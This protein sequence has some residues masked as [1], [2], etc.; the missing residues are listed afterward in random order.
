M[1]MA[2]VEN[3]ALSDAYCHQKGIFPAREAVVMQQQDRGIEGVHA[4]NVFVGNGVSE[5]IMQCMRALLDPGDGLGPS[6]DYPLWTA[7]VVIHGGQAVHYPC[8][9][10][11]N[12]CPDQDEV[13]SL[14]T[15]RTRAIVIINPN[16]PTGAVYPRGSSSRN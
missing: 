3:M 13:E 1:R 14:L 16:N 9:P 8:R 12:F 4:D 5:P 10:E 11:N 7:S 6:P 2:M 15:P